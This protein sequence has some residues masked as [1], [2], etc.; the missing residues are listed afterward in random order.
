MH[1][2]LPGV[3]VGVILLQSA[4]V[5]PMLA[6]LLDR[7]EFGRVIRV[8]W[9]R[10]FQGLMLLG[11]ASLVMRLLS[12]DGSMARL[13]MSGTTLGGAGLCHAII[14]ATNRATDMGDA[15]RF[16][17]LHVVSVLVTIFILVGNA[18]V[19]FL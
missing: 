11:S 8:I 16:Q 7:G 2:F 10:F 6:R 12:D 19:A 4:V 18:V 9:P 1:S 17:L 14:P 3:I 13:V 15:R 5:A